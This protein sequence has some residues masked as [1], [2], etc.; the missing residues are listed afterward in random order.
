MSRGSRLS[1]AET[2]RESGKA[3][4]RPVSGNSVSILMATSQVLF[5]VSRDKR[6]VMRRTENNEQ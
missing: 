2:R 3:P 1:E 4:M 5:E 6:Y